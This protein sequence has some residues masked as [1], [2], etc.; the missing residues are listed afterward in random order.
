M[1]VLS[2]RSAPQGTAIK[3]SQRKPQKHALCLKALHYL[4][5]V[6]H[7]SS[8]RLLHDPHELHFLHLL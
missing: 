7:Y 5:Q 4:S 2:T 6:E 8:K 1:E 3:A